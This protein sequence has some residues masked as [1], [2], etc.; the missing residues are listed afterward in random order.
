MWITLPR[1][2][3]VT[4]KRFSQPQGFLT[5]S[6]KLAQSQPF[7]ERGQQLFDPLL[8]ASLAVY[9]NQRLRAG[10]AHQHPAA[11]LQVVLEA[12]IGP[13]AHHAPARDLRRRLLLQPAIE[14]RAPRR[15]LL[16]VQVQVMTRVEMRPHQLGQTLHD[17]ESGC[18]YLTIMSAKEIPERT[19]SRSGMW[20][21]KAKPPL[22]SP[23]SMALV[24]AI[25]GPMYLKPT[26]S[27][28]TFTPKRSPSLS[29]IEVEVSE[30]TTSPFCPRFSTRYII[31]S[32][33]TCS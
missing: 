11:V 14:L 12:V 23:P 33:I 10:K 21:R 17:L 28:C 1:Y 24:S 32:A 22:S 30:R 19:P 9:P 15:V 26:L 3:S 5:I 7:F 16:A 13:R 20:P 27:S 4:A 8:R 29:T 6:D 25:F 18:P 2:L 31:S